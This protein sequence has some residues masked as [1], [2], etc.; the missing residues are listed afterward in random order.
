MAQFTPPPAAGGE[1]PR[2]LTAAVVLIVSA[3]AAVAGLLLLRR[4]I[5]ALS[6][7]TLC[8]SCNRYFS[9]RR[10]ACPFCGSRGTHSAG[11]AGGAQGNQPATGQ[12]DNE[13]AEGT[14][15]GTADDQDEA[16]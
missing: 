6:P 16:Q 2:G 14:P 5:R 9:T 12:T 10:E 8:E 11:H 7:R 1:I 4:L 15:E 3:A 13:A